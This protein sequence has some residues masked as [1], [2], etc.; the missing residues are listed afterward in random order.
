M[1]ARIRTPSVRCA[2]VALALSLAAAIAPAAAVAAGP[3][4]TVFSKQSAQPLTLSG[5]QVAAAADVSPRT[6]TLRERPGS[7]GKT[8]RLRGLS[9]R[10]LLDRAGIDAG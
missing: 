5:S 3:G 4:V 8:L 10:G 7:A 2:L 9:I 6:Y 1:P